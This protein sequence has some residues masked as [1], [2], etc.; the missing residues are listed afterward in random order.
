[1]KNYRVTI[2]KR[3]HAHLDA[4]S[5]R[6]LHKFPEVIYLVMELLGLEQSSDR[7]AVRKIIC[8][9]V[10]NA[11]LNRAQHWLHIFTRDYNLED[12]KFS[13]EKMRSQF[14][15]SNRLL[16]SNS[17]SFV[18]SQIAAYSQFCTRQQITQK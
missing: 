7:E 9:P 1:M 13:F 14:D 11:V 8:G 10:R 18:D 12:T 15:L 17:F 4:M 5:L 6:S 2:E 3:L 16:R